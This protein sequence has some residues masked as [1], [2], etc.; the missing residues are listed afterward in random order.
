MNYSRFNYNTIYS[1]NL[2]INGDINL[3]PKWK[4]GYNTGYNFN[5]KKIAY[6]QFEVSRL[7]HCWALNF[8]W[9]PDGIRKSFYFSLKANSSILQSLKVEKRRYWWD[10]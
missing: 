1:Q 9:I 3:T 4:I 5:D 8:S 2:T 10:Q 7:L 6:T